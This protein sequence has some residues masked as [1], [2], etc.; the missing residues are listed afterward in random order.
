MFPGDSLKPSARDAEKTRGPALKTHTKLS[1]LGLSLHFQADSLVPQHTHLLPQCH[2]VRPFVK[3]RREEGS[4]GGK[5][6]AL[7]GARR[8]AKEHVGTS[9]SCCALP[10]PPARLL[11]QSAGLPG[12]PW[13]VMSLSPRDREVGLTAEM[14][15]AELLR[16]QAPWGRARRDAIAPDCQSVIR[17]P[18]F[19][20]PPPCS[21]AP[22]SS[23]QL[24][25]QPRE[26]YISQ[27]HLAP[28]P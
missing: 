9:M 3:D 11:R 28:G 20:R 17:N 16:K 10:P 14:T 25:W 1:P 8:G 21:P 12:L 4:A 13:G 24:S 26:L 27:G 22:Q 18:G 19:V 6:S 7:P 2:S 23:A 15:R 5:T